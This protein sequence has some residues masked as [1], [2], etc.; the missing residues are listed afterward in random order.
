MSCEVYDWLDNLHKA[1]PELACIVVSL[2]D[3]DEGDSVEAQLQTTWPDR[4]EVDY[5]ED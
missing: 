5:C 4:W 2:F 1:A 3:T